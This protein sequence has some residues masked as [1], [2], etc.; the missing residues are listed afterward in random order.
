[1]Q[2]HSGLVLSGWSLVLKSQ[3]PEQAHESSLWIGTGESF[4]CC[5][6]KWVG[7]VTRGE[8]DSWL[9]MVRTRLHGVTDEREI[10]Q[11][12]HMILTLG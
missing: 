2:L 10:V 11:G 9:N 4:C 8:K 6:Q 7:S 5:R 3:R 1:M 12:D